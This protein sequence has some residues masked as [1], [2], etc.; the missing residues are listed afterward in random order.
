MQQGVQ[1]DATCHIQQCYVR[2][3]GALLMTMRKAS[4]ISRDFC[5]NIKN[6]DLRGNVLMIKYRKTYIFF[7]FKCSFVFK[8]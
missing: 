2:L 3:H 7:D 6:K 4:R 5:P 8:T 1:M